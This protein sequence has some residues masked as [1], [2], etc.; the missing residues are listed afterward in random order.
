MGHLYDD[1]LPA[2]W[3]DQ[4]ACL[5]VYAPRETHAILDLVPDRLGH[6]CCLDADLEAKLLKSRI[7][8]E[9]CLS[10]NV[11][12]ESVPTYAEHHFAKLYRQGLLCLEKHHA[13]ACKLAGPAEMQAKA[14]TLICTCAPALL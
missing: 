1:E 6:M 7:P 12:T 8:V 4:Q 5:Q 14:Q 9:L 3:I 11:I 2:A 10:S 13:C